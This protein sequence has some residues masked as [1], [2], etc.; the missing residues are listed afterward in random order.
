MRTETQKKVVGKQY[1]PMTC[2]YCGKAIFRDAEYVAKKLRRSGK[3]L[4]Y[5]TPSHMVKH[6]RKH[7]TGQ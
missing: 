4:S 1:V 5:C 3:F 6:Q 7:W 2:A